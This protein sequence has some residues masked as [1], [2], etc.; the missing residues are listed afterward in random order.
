[1]R[2]RVMRRALAVL[3]LAAIYAAAPA[4]GGDEGQEPVLSVTDMKVDTGPEGSD[5]SLAV[6]FDDNRDQVCIALRD[7][8]RKTVHV[9]LR[10]VPY[11]VTVAK[12]TASGVTPRSMIE[13]CYELESTDSTVPY[14]WYVWLDNPDAGHFR[15]FIT[16]DGH[17]YLT[18]VDGW[19]LC[20]A[21]TSKPIDKPERRKRLEDHLNARDRAGTDRVFVAGII[22]YEQ[23]ID[24]N[25]SA[26]SVSVYLTSL[27]K[28]SKGGFRLQLH[29]K[30]PSKVYTL[31]SDKA[32]EWGWR[33]AD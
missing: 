31:L 11:R 23:F 22:G 20:L 26:H 12:H 14:T 27:E 7:G 13:H 28:D 16:P 1:M 19:S 17:T 21:E 3:V 18:W 24:K 2:R 9:R 15:L 4:L 30:D 29:G 25:T 8:T 32:A 6:P 5:R 33:L 10:N